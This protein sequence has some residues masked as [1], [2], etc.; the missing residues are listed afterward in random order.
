MLQKRYNEMC[1]I[2]AILFQSHDWVLQV[3]DKIIKHGS[4]V[5]VLKIIPVMQ[6][7]ILW[8]GCHFVY[9]E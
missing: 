7:M 5:A 8:L 3:S 1:D 9:H 6:T 2:L 4:L